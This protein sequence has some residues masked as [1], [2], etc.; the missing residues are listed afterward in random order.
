LDQGYWTKIYSSAI[1]GDEVKEDGKL[2]IS[3]DNNYLYQF[4]CLMFTN[5]LKN[6]LYDYEFKVNNDSGINRTDNMVIY[7][8]KENLNVYLEIIKYLK[9]QYPEFKINSSHMLGK[10]ISDGVVIAKDYKDGSNFTE[11]VCKTILGLKNK[12][13]MMKLLL[14]Q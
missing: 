13:M 6:H 4:A 3:I 12:D 2:Y 7:F 10:E 5:C 14:N 1:T 11:K 8:T 9:Q